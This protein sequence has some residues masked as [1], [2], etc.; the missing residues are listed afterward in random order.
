MS[1]CTLSTQL[2]FAN[3]KKYLQLRRN[4]KDTLWVC[5]IS[6]FQITFYKHRLLFL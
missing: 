6:L 2:N 1:F 3:V 5:L 4:M